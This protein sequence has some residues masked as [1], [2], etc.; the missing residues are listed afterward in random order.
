[1]ITHAF[2][3]ALLFMRVGNLIHSS[4]DYQDLRK[5]KIS[6]INIPLYSSLLINTNLRLR[7]FPFFAGFYS[8]DMWLESVPFGE[9][10]IFIYLVFL[11]AVIITVLYSAR[12]I[13]FLLIRN[14]ESLSLTSEIGGSDKPEWGTNLPTFFRLWVYSLVS[15]SRLR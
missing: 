14:V 4:N 13:F 5:S 2:T 3:K 15:G 9:F 10:S 12:L 7:G 1:M 6:V 8:K 11:I